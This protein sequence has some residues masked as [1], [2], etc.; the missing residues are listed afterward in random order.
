M[1]SKKRFGVIVIICISL[2]FSLLVTNIYAVDE[3]EESSGNTRRN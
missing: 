3:G 2:I 1:K